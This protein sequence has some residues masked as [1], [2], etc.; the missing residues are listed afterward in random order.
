L[1]IRRVRRSTCL[2]RFERRRDS[3]DSGGF[4]FGH[5]EL[6]GRAGYPV[7]ERKIEETILHIWVGAVALQHRK[8]VGAVT[9]ATWSEQVQRSADLIAGRVP[10]F[11]REEFVAY[12]N[13][14]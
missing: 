2:R 11:D 7:A 6:A 12:C 9:K 13:K 4:P 8:L 10:D 14:K 5:D 3:N 1:A